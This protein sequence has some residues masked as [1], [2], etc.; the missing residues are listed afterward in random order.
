MR[1]MTR[2][3]SDGSYANGPPIT[4]CHGRWQI[5]CSHGPRQR[6]ERRSPWVNC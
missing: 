1:T 2:D 6:D 5:F 4:G 3:Q